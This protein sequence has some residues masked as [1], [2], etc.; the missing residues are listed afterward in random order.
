[1]KYCAKYATQRIIQETGR[2]QEQ[3]HISKK[4][5]R[6]E[7]KKAVKMSSVGDLQIGFSCRFTKIY[8]DDMINL[9]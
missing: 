4:T 2:K 3:T 5:G 8:K 7:G 9:Q 1:M 6:M